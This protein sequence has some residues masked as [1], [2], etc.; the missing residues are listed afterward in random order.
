LLTNKL[1]KRTTSKPRGKPLL[2]N[3]LLDIFRSE[4]V[5][6]NPIA[7]LAKTLGDVDINFVLSKAKEVAESLQALAS[8]ESEP[9]E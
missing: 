3:S 8:P 6:E 9:L 5:E 1:L 4:D 7:T 2:G